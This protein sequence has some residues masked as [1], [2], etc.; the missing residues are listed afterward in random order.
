[1]LFNQI[2]TFFTCL[3]QA[4]ASWPSLGLEPER[5][6]HHKPRM[7]LSEVIDRAAQDRVL[8][9][10]CRNPVSTGCLRAAPERAM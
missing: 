2:S 9:K 7:P 8:V 1:M 6:A 4:E 5:L 10:A 3:C